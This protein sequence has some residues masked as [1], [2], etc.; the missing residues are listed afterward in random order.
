MRFNPKRFDRHLKNI[1]QQ[2]AWRRA[3]ACACVNPASGAPDP[4]HTLCGGKG[5]FWADPVD[6]VVGIAK[7]VV[8][9][10]M[11]ALGIWDSGDMV[12]TVP[13]ESP[14]WAEAGKF[15]RVVLRNSTDVF[16]QPL[17]R[18]GVN[19][20]LI[21]PVASV[22]RCFW[23]HPT[24]RMPVDGALP[25]IVN[26]VPT[27]PNGGEPPPGV[28]YSLTGQKFDEY[29]ILDSLPS[30][31]NEHSGMQLPKRISLRKFDLFGR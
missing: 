25:V 3:F 27:W 9:P 13:Q 7:Q 31:R 12:M 26:G 30:D 8:T 28:T 21:F 17:T 15:D 4:K 29:F 6:T 23:L 16:S 19:E 11:A 18:G 5:R 1:G 22:S 20:K 24:T 2:V 10:E 14:M